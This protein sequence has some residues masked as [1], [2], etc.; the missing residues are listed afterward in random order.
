MPRSRGGLSLD[1]ALSALAWGCLIKALRVR[2]STQDDWWRDVV[3]VCWGGGG[4]GAAGGG[5]HGETL[6]Q[7]DSAT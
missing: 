2:E 1:V 4:G 3:A 5:G 7:S 6:T